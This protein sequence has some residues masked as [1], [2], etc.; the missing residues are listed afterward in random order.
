LR[1]SSPP[2]FPLLPILGK[3]LHVLTIAQNVPVAGVERNLN[4]V[5]MAK[6]AD[7]GEVCKDMTA[8]ILPPG[9]AHDNSG[10]RRAVR[11]IA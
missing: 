7:I 5:A 1:L 2:T 11:S 4:V 6:P 8:T 9:D 10:D 3:N